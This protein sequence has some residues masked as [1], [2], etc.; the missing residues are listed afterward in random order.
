MGSRKLGVPCE[1][2]AIVRAVAGPGAICAPSRAPGTLTPPRHIWTHKGA[3]LS[4]SG[5]SA[6]SEETGDGIVSLFRGMKVLLTMTSK[7]EMRGEV[8]SQQMTQLQFTQSPAFILSLKGHYNFFL[9][10]RELY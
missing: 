4:L 2:V 3:S 6:E 9:R 8:M 7:I 5:L 1:N 10:K